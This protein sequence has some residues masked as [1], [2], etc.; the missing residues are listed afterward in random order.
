MK[1]LVD[2]ALSPELARILQTAGH[3]AVHVRDRN[4]Q[5]AADEVIFEAAA[6]EG[7][8]IVSADTDF[9]AI[10]TLRRQTH[11]SLILFRNPSPRRA[12]PQAQLLLT[13]LPSF[14]DD[15]EQGAIVVLRLDRIRIRR[16]G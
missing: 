1:L 16:T 13:N 3:D 11:P 6:A 12:E 7:R 2:N 4:L 8:V 5:H 15:L 9:G 10:L 14:R